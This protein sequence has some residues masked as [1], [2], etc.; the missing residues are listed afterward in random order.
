MK[1]NVR[2]IRE[3]KKISQTKLAELAGISRPGLSTIENNHKQAS[4]ET[5][6][7]IADALNMSVDDVFFNKNVRLVIQGTE[8]SAKIT[9]SS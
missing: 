1:N 3:Y 2:V 7:K 4:L 8:H 5:A 9:A 6:G